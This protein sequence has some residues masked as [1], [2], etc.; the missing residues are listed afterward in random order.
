ME[1]PF[2]SEKPAIDLA[3][4][5]RTIGNCLKEAA[6]L[7]RQNR[8]PSIFLWNNIADSEPFLFD[9]LSGCERSAWNQ[10]LYREAAGLTF[11]FLIRQQENLKLNGKVE[12]TEEDGRDMARRL[13]EFSNK[14]N[15]AN[16]ALLFTDFG[17][18]REEMEKISP[19]FIK[20]VGD[21]VELISKKYLDERMTAES[22]I[23]QARS[24]SLGAYLTIFPF[25]SQMMER[26]INR[27]LYVETPEGSDPPKS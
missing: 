25:Y 5:Q 8:G 12:I 24:F 6:E 18:L 19:A 13:K 11:L 4:T 14:N 9:F 1:T 27:M 15:N 20:F 2:G 7:K 23:K 17:L 26:K 21:R 10:D 16:N 22:V 3:I